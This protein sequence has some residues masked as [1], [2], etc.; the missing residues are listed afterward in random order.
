MDYQVVH[1]ANADLVMVEGSW[2]VPARPIRAAFLLS[3]EGQKRPNATPR[4][5]LFQDGRIVLTVTGNGD[6]K[7][8]M[9]P[10]IQDVTATKA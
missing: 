8:K 10:M 3:E 1:P 5:I 2:P 6:W 7:D 9:W 4:F